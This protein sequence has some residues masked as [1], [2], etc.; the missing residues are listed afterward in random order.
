MQCR[1][2]LAECQAVFLLQGTIAGCKV[3]EFAGG[4][5]AGKGEVPDGLGAAEC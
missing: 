2:G 3:G 4:W 1:E 5:W